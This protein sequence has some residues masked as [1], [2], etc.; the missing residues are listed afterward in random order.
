MQRELIKLFA[1]A[2]DKRCFLT[3][4][5][6]IVYDRL[7]HD[8]QDWLVHVWFGPWDG[9]PD[10]FLDISTHKACVSSKMSSQCVFCLDDMDDE[11]L[12]IMLD[13]CKHRMHTSCFMDYIKHN[14]NKQD[15]IVCPI[16]RHVVINM[17]TRTY[18]F[19]TP[20][21][22]PVVYVRAPR[23]EVTPENVS[24]DC[25]RHLLLPIA[26]VVFLGLNLYWT[27]S[28]K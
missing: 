10:Q 16:C 7:Q 27:L 13:G 8:L 23:H 24:Q 21:M 12:T 6:H 26:I 1:H 17:P 28:M 25:G 3:R 2:L 11:R 15:D 18:N 9:V 5:G 14:I 4:K 19:P 20:P 22:A